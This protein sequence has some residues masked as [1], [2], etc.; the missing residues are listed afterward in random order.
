MDDR[1][2]S[3]T[4][5]WA[6]LIPMA[7]LFVTGGIGIAFGE[8]RDARNAKEAQRK[9][10]ELQ[11]ELLVNPAPEAPYKIPY[12][13]ARPDWVQV[14][15]MDLN[16]VSG[17]AVN[18]EGEGGWAVNDEVG[19]LYPIALAE[20]L[21]GSP[22]RFAG[23][24]DY[25]GVEIVGDEVVVAR[26]DG[27]LLRARQGQ[28]TEVESM[29]DYDYDVEGLALDGARSRLL[30]ACKGKAGPGKAYQRKRAIYSLSLPGFAWNETPAYVIGFKELKKF[31]RDVDVP[32][33]KG[34]QAKHF[35]PSA[36]AVTP[37][38]Q[39][40]YIASS[41]GHMMVVL[42]IKGEIVAVADLPRA[43]HRQPEGLAF[44]GHGSLYIANEGRDR[45]G[46]IYRFDL[47]N[48]EDPDDEAIEDIDDS[49]SSTDAH[50]VP[51]AAENSE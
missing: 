29:L 38:D 15:P 51:P 40:I 26:S 7:V 21:L 39:H 19:S 30:V 2:N 36:I 5:D 20:G 16:E 50:P 28:T 11:K 42:N 23:R 47:L 18:I 25:E 27:T 3:E 34:N 32:H 37:D 13:F 43:V 24:G 44:D 41:V 6:F 31:I 8:I 14:L 10:A 17:F 1:H 9:Q 45:S 35:A 48:H 46:V 4:I 49:V 22:F 12:D 33:M